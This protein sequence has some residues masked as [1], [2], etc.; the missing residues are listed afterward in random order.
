MLSATERAI[1]VPHRFCGPPQSGNGGYTCGLLAQALPDVAAVECTIRRP[2]PLD[3]ELRVDVTQSVSRLF[4]GEDVVIEA[5]PKDFEVN[6]PRATSFVEAQ[7]A[8]PAFFEHPFPTCFVC[9]PERHEHDGLEIFPASSVAQP[10]FANLYSAVWIPADEFGDDNGNVRCEFI[11]AAMDCPTGFAAGFP[12]T[13]KLVTGRL[14]LK[15]LKPLQTGSHCV[16][17]SWSL[18]EDGRKCHAAA[19]LRNESNVLVALAKA[20]WIR[21]A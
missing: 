14:A 13:G 19:A 4:D 15:L 6:P 11:W 18:G 10:G 12:Y 16:V 9:G 20:T 2:I 1:V 17:Q 7:S 21:V 8:T 5:T 3:T